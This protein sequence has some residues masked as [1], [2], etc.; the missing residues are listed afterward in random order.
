MLAGALYGEIGPSR[1]AASRILW[2]PTWSKNENANSRH[3]AAEYYRRNSKISASSKSQSVGSAN[4]WFVLRNRS[5]NSGDHAIKGHQNLSSQSRLAASRVIVYRRTRLL[6]LVPPILQQTV[7]P[8]IFRKVLF[9]I[10]LRRF[11]WF[12]ART[13]MGGANPMTPDPAHR[14]PAEPRPIEWLEFRGICPDN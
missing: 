11:F 13:I 6:G 8:S 5:T 10:S 7:C 12:G 1:D 3:L 2:I 4:I 9:S 14:A